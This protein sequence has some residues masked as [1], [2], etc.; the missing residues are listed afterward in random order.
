MW[1]CG[2]GRVKGRFAVRVLILLVLDF[3]ILD[4]DLDGL[5]GYFE[6]DD[7]VDVL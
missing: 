3:F 5:L 7:G 6:G 2:C 4:L 1:S